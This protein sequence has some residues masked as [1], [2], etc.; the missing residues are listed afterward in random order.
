MDLNK[1]KNPDTILRPAPFWAIND[2]L[3]PEECA[4]QMEEMISVGL[5]GGFFHSRSGLYTEY[6]KDEWF[7]CMRAS[8]EAAEKHGGYMWLYDEDLWPSG[9][10]GGR[11]A[12]FKDEYRAAGLREELVPVGEKPDDFTDDFR[13]A[14]LLS[15]RK[16]AEVE[17]IEKISLEEARK[18]TDS[19]RLLIRRV[20]KGKT[21]WW[22]GE[23]YANLLDPEAM[24]YFIELTH[25]VYKKELGD[26]F[27]KGIPG[28]F[29]DEPNI[30]E[31]G[32]G[33]AWWDGIPEVYKK[34]HGR[35]FWADLPYMYLEGPEAKK[36]RLLV[37]RTIGRQFREA[38]SKQLFD[39]CEENGLLH[40]GHFNCEEQLWR[41]ITDNYC[42]VMAHYRYEHIPG[43]DHLCR[44][45]DGR[46]GC[47]S[48]L[49]AAKQ[50]SSAARQLGRKVV[51]TEIFGV[52]RYS[53]TFEDFKWIGDFDQVMGA[54]FFCPHLTLYSMKGK[55]KR[56]Y[57]PNWNYQA[58]YWKDLNPLNDYFTRVA[59]ALTTGEGKPEVL[60]LHPIESGTAGHRLK[61]RPSEGA[62]CIP[63]DLPGEDFEWA[64]HAEDR[65]FVTMR[66]LTYA[67]YDYDLGEEDYF[68]DMASIEGSR[69]RI[70]E[71]S[72]P[73]VIVP[74]SLTWRP[75]TFELLK[76]FT[77]AGG[78]LIIVGEFPTMIECE[79]ASEEWKRLASSAQAVPCSTVQIQNAVDAVAKASYRLRGPDGRAVPYLHVQHRMDGDQ[80]ILFITN[81][82]R[83]RSHEYTLTFFDKS[84]LPA[85]VLNPLDGTSAKIEFTKVGRDLRYSFKLPPT[86]SL[87]VLAGPGADKGASPMP[88]PVYLKKGAAAPI[89]GSYK[90]ARSED[91]VL[92]MDRL[93]YSL[94]GGKTW[95]AEDM[96]W[97]IRRS[98]AEH[99]GTRDSLGWQPWVAVKKGLFDGKGGPVTLRYK[100]KS[101]VDKPK[102]A[103]LVIEEIEKGRLTVNG[104]AVDTSDA[105]WHWDMSFGKVEITNL[106]KKGENIVEFSLDYDFTTEVEA[107]YV[108]GDF[109]VRMAN[110]FEGEIIEEP[111]V[112]ENGSWI[113]Q[114]FPFY[115][116][117]INYLTDVEVPADGKRTFLRL[118]NPSGIFYKVRVNGRDAGKILWRP[119]EIELTSLMHPGGNRLEIEIVGSRQN[120]IGPLHEKN[121]DDNMWCG[122]DAFQD[123]RFVKEE[124]SLFDYGL[125]GGAEI[126]RVDK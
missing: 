58:N 12:G 23:S 78:N 126:V 45:I 62:N 4:R 32:I 65:L 59:Q 100:F 1:F 91:N 19:E 42:G 29:T 120:T 96:E 27:G 122:P 75:R 101:A 97:R 88:K 107:I 17:K 18:R 72:Y 48:M 106:I 7:A 43:I 90:F 13:A 46:T 123:D 116:G 99:F 93:T 54:N 102:K 86:G 53:S 40:T 85:A 9:N 5:S 114:G 2:K 83:D 8:L 74:P 3:K 26:H 49:T 21:N 39:W 10:A 63:P 38:Y 110:P 95:L 25:E 67:G 109:G 35:D 73:I 44:Q 47:A 60:I 89:T 30:E 57:P 115:S 112:I 16:G 61:L 104:Q 98:I 105:S 69:F 6:M 76:Q 77:A 56:D 82:D 37:H 111:T 87:L 31:K 11:V 28:I 94:D 41:Q 80:E 84:E 36:I 119:W 24:R 20:Y 81:S 113:T 55:R 121:G 103:S 125:L 64:Y 51:L 14:Y 108:V 15:G 52:S 92:V 117:S 33:F 34:W 124:F 22:S 66:A 79:N 50:V 71:M 70:G 68:D 118:V